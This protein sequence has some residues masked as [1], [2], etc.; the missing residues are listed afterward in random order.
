MTNE[1]DVVTFDYNVNVVLSQKF[2]RMIDWY[3]GE[4]DKEI[5]GFIIGEVKDNGE[6]YCEDII[7]PKQK[8]SGSEVEFLDGAVGL[9]R[10]EYGEE[11]CLKIIG[12][13][14]SHV[15]MGCFWSRTDN[16]DMIDK[17]MKDWEVGIFIVSSDYKH[18]VRVDLSKPF[19]VSIDNLD[20]D[21]EEVVDL[22]VENLKKQLKEHLSKQKE[23]LET[24]C[25]EIVTNKVDETNY[26]YEKYNKKDLENKYPKTDGDWDKYHNYYSQFYKEEFDYDRERMIDYKLYDL[27]MTDK[28]NRIIELNKLSPYWADEI[29]NHFPDGILNRDSIQNTFKFSVSSPNKQDFKKLKKEVKGLMRILLTKDIDFGE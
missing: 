20:F 21:V 27:I 11:T 22:E 19:M 5:G 3:S 29:Y 18:L 25:K 1:K 28:R 24:K 8:V 15:K 23:E 4:Y 26:S 7:F 13:W 10:K 9:L 17:F 16:A 2:K 14:H 12:E 6:I